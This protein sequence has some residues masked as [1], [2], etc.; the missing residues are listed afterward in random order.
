ME[1]LP[2]PPPEGGADG[3]GT[4]QNVNKCVRNR[5]RT[6]GYNK[7][8]RVEMRTLKLC[9][10][11]ALVVALGGP[12]WGLTLKNYTNGDELIFNLFDKTDGKIYGIPSNNTVYGETNVD[13][14]EAS[15]WGHAKMTWDTGAVGS[16][17]EE[18]F[19]G[20]AFVNTINNID[21]SITYWE[22][23]DTN[24]ELTIIFWG[25]RDQ[26]VDVGNLGT[27]TYTRGIMARMYEVPF[28]T[29]D[30]LTLGPAG[31]DNNADGFVTDGEEDSYPTVDIGVPIVELVGANIISTAWAV[32]SG[33]VASVSHYNTI[34]ALV[35]GADGGGLAYFDVADLGNGGGTMG[36]FFDTDSVGT[37]LGTADFKANFSIEV[38]NLDPT[39]KTTWVTD[40]KDPLKTALIP[41]PAT[42]LCVVFGV[43]ALGGYA[44]KRRS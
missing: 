41:E 28:G 34:N 3:S 38:E 26:I 31:R 43:A 9:T 4:R 36:S 35:T 6:Q 22:T 15:G 29:H 33:G 25:G 7:K 27:T 8:G 32:L 18:D 1:H 16:Q 39:D 2:N 44:R 13:S 12:A 5:E 17:S 23:S 40:S 37:S 10:M 24:T 21:G 20:I 14:W 30:F 11:V 19:W 42:M